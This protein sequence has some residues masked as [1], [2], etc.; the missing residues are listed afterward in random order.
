MTRILPSVTTSRDWRDLIAEASRLGLTEV[1]FFPTL[2]GKEERQEAYGLL[3][4]S[5]I[6]HIPFVHLRSDMSP[7]EIVYLN[8]KF[9]TEIFNIHPTTE[10]PLQYDLGNWKKKIYIETVD[11][12]LEEAELE[13]FAGICADISHI[14][15]YRRDNLVYYESI[16]RLMTRYPVGC[17]HVSASRLDESGK[18]KAPHYFEELSDFDYVTNYRDII[19]P[20]IAL[21]LTNSLAEQLEAADYIEKLLKVI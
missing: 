12:P 9:G 11:Q 13:Q 7:A 10:F 1:C 15:R 8:D 21:E 4:K 17:W 16:R 18:T 20:I 14:E 2:L 3:E 19:P 6:K 5:T